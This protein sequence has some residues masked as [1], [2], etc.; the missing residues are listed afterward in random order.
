MMTSTSNKLFQ[1][2][3]LDNDFCEI[4]Q[5]TTMLKKQL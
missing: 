3:R 1:V 4:A 2:K 5:Y